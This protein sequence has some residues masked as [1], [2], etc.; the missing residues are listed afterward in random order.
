[1][2][3][4]DMCI[5]PYYNAEAYAITA[6]A[7]TNHFY[8]DYL[9]Y[10]FHL[11]IAIRN[12]KRFIHLIPQ[13]DRLHVVNGIWLHDAIEDARL[14]YNDILKETKSKI[15]AEIARAC[16]NYTRGRNRDERMP[17]FVYEDIRNTQYAT[18][19]KL[20]D[21]MANVQYSKMIGSN[22]FQMYKDEHEHF[23]DQLRHVDNLLPM[24]EYLDRLFTD[25]S[26]YF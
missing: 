10:E 4:N 22:K 3:E 25:S 13:E 5:I 26:F 11:R 19:A 7:S 6:H 14:S 21:R 1:M 8:D 18:F 2:M 23:S 24:W 12:Y 17:D 20:C 15:T 9:P 16:T